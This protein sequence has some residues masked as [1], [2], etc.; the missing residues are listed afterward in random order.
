MKKNR[1]G[2]RVESIFAIAVA[3][4]ENER[5]R[6]T[7]YC[8]GN[9]VYVMNSDNTVLLHFPLKGAEKPF[10]HSVAFK[11]ADYESPEFGE[12]EEGR[13]V[14][15]SSAEGYEKKVSCK[16]PERTPEEAAALFAKYSSLKES[17]Y[18]VSFS[19]SFLSLLDRDLSHVEFA[20]EKD[21]L[22][23]RQRNIYSGALIEITPKK[24]SLLG[25][26]KGQL[27]EFGPIALRTTDFCA[28]FSFHETLTFRFTDKL[29]YC[30][31]HGRNTLYSMRGVI[32]QC[33][34][35]E[36]GVVQRSDIAKDSQDG[37]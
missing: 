33:L 25:R 20:V 22:W 24:A 18:E 14:F 34:Y 10:A 13:I 21:R 8:T 15:L 12:D 17:S 27:T 3:L 36:L 28:L 16:A 35:D 31:V 11:A 7:I 6:N 23:I 4:S 9:S 5:M 32:S 2:N 30:T 29:G 1:V 26:V 37:S 19:S